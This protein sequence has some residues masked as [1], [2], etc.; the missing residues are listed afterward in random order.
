[1]T[2]TYREDLTGKEFGRL[3][4]LRKAEKPDHIKDNDPFW[5]C[6]CECG[7]KKV[8]RGR[9]LK[10]GSTASCGCKRKENSKDKLIDLKGKKFGKL[11]VIEQT[12]RPLQVRNKRP[13]WLCKCDCGKTKVVLG[14]NLRKGYTTSCGCIGRGRK[15]KI[16][17]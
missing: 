9:S 2:R 12:D 17:P 11:S 4:V 13:Y 14:L 15:K 5:L 10:N 3:L 6:L 7:E 8:V 16:A 1:M